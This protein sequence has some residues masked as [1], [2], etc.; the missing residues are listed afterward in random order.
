MRIQKFVMIVLIVGLLGIAQG[1]IDKV[2]F[3]KYEDSKPK[4]DAFHD[5]LETV[6]SLMTDVI[7]LSGGR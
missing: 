4:R 3:V 2:I 1:R 6:E 5:A 7:R